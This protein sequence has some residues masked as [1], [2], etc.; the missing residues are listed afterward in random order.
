M[1]APY[2]VRLKRSAVKELRKVPSRDLERIVR[3]MDSLSRNPR[4][5]GVQKLVAEKAYRIRQSDYRIVYLI[6]DNAK[7]VEV[8]K[9]GHRGEVY[10]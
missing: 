10:R 3:E 9:I 6:D 2:T 1:P 8:V 5:A 7:T 4:P